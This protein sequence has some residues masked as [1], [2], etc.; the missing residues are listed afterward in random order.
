[1]PR[2]AH[3]IGLYNRSFPR[4]GVSEATGLGRENLPVVLR[5]LSVTKQALNL[6]AHMDLV[7]ALETKHRSRR[8]AWKSKLPPGLRGVPRQA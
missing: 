1:M 6:E 3:R 8:D 7:T 4:I 5:S 2:T